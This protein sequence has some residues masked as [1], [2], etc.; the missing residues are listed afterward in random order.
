MQQQPAFSNQDWTQTNLIISLYFNGQVGKHNQLPIN[1]INIQDMPV[2]SAI[3]SPWTKQ[4]VIHNGTIEVKGW[5][6]SGGG[7]WPGK[8]SHSNQ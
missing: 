3:M 5:A 2:S 4:V 6:Y 1:G 8:Q 7:R